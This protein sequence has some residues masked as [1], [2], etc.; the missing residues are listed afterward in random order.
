VK[1]LTEGLID[2]GWSPSDLA[3]MTGMYYD[4]AIYNTQRAISDGYP[5]LDLK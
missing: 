2:L 5:C 3:T 1:N 4:W